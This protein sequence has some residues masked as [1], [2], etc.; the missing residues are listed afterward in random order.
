MAETKDLQSKQASPDPIVLTVDGKDYKIHEYHVDFFEQLQRLP[1]AVRISLMNLTTNQMQS[2]IRKKRANAYSKAVDLLSK[3][4]YW[5]ET[6]DPVEITKETILGVDYTPKEML[7]K[8]RS[9]E[10]LEKIIEFFEGENREVYL[11]ENN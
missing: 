9:L 1:P 4:W 11:K 8:N 3:Q 7:A 5:R 10:I 6:G 2:Y